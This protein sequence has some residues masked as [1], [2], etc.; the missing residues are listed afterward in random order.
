[1]SYCSDLT[2]KQF[3]NELARS[4]SFLHGYLFCTDHNTEKNIHHHSFS[5]DDEDM[6]FYNLKILTQKGKL[7]TFY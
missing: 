1:M 6:V 5:I 3:F 4:P 7:G 2:T